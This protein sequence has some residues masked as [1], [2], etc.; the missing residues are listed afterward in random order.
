LTG[1]CASPTLAGQLDS[2]LER[3]PEARWYGDAPA[4]EAESLTAT[5]AAFG[6]ALLPRADLRQATVILAL[7]TGRPG[8]RWRPRPGREVRLAAAAG[9]LFLGFMAE[10]DHDIGRAA[11]RP[12]HQIPWRGWVEVLERTV[13]KTSENSITLVAAGV[14]FYALLAIFPAIG[15]LISIYGLVSDPAQAD[16]QFAGI[17]GWNVRPRWTRPATVISRWVGAAPTSP[18][19]CRQ[20]PA[21]Q[22][23]FQTVCEHQNAMHRRSPAAA[24]DMVRDQEEMR[25][26]TPL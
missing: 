17:R 3:L 13:R 14:A 24:A 23:C 26:A 10:G 9:F 1:T 25:G 22:F 20:N 5:R 6:E 7:D 16:Q 12:H 15:A 4:G 8:L 18:T 11:R 19:I 2:L 21:D